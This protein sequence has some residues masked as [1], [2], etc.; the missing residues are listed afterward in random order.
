M[1]W[2]KTFLLSLLLS[3]TAI[4][5]G[6]FQSYHLPQIKSWLLLTIEKESRRQLPVQ[7]SSKSIDITLF[8]IG[9]RVYDVQVTPNKELQ[10]KIEPTRIK[11]ISIYLSISSLFKKQI[12]FKQ[13]KFVGGSLRYTHEKKHIPTSQKADNAKNLITSTV[14]DLLSIKSLQKLMV[15][16]LTLENIDIQVRD[17]ERNSTLTIQSL[18]LDLHV[19]SQGFLIIVNT[20]SLTLKEDSRSP[21][22]IDFFASLRVNENQIQVI[23]S[24]IKQGNGSLRTQGIIRG[25]FNQ[26]KYQSLDLAASGRL[27]LQESGQLAKSLFPTQQIPDLTGDAI[28]NIQAKHKYLH[29]P[30]LQIKLISEQTSI[31]KLQLG[32]LEIKGK[33]DTNGFQTSSFQIKN[34]GANV[35]I[36][37]FQIKFKDKY[38]FEGDLRLSQLNL[39]QLLKSINGKTTP[40]ELDGSGQ[41]PCKGQLKP[42]FEIQC[43]QLK[44]S[45][46]RF[47]I[48]GKKQ[49]GKKPNT[50]LD[51]KKI[52]VTEGDLQITKEQFT[53]KSN[54]GF[55]EANG[56]VNAVVNLQKNKDFHVK[57]NINIKD[58]LKIDDLVRL[59]L[60]GAA[61]VNGY[62]RGGKNSSTSITAN[63]RGNQ[64]SLQGWLLGSTNIPLQY[65]KGVIRATQI[66]GHINSSHY[67]GNLSIN[68]PK[69]KISLN[70]DFPSF[71]GKPLNKFLKSKFKLNT[72]FNGIGKL[73][74]NLQGDLSQPQYKIKSN[75]EGSLY[76]QSFDSLTFNISGKRSRINSDKILIQKG[77]G[78]LS[79]NGS[80]Y[81]SPDTKKVHANLQLKGQGIDIGK[82]DLLKNIDSNISGQL[83]FTSD[84]TGPTQNI[85]MDLK[86]KVS[87]F[88][89]DN[90]PL[91]NSDFQVQINKNQISGNIQLMGKTVESKFNLHTDHKGPFSLFLKTKK[92]NFM[93]LLSAFS[94]YAESEVLTSSITSQINLTSKNGNPW[95]SHGHGV[96]SQLEIQQDAKSMNTPQPIEFL[97][98]NGSMNTK[99]FK[100]VG[101]ESSLTLKSDHSTQDNLNIHLH[102]QIDLGFIKPF[103]PSLNTLK[104]QV[105]FD[106]L[107]FGPLNKMKAKGS[108]QIKRSTIEFKEF[109][110]PIEGL[111]TRISFNKHHISI[112]DLKA[113]VAGGELLS[114][115]TIHFKGKNHT[116]I[117]IKTYFNDVS[118]NMPKGIH[119]NGYGQ[120]ELTGKSPP[121]N[122]NGNYTIMGGNVSTH[123]D[124]LYPKKTKHI[125]IRSRLL[126]QA[127]KK[128]D[129]PSPLNLNFSFD[130]KNPLIVKTEFQ[131]SKIDARLNGN[132]KLLGPAN[133][134]LA[135]GNIGIEPGGTFQM[136]SHTFDI[137][138]AQFTYD[139]SPI[140]RPRLLVSSDTLIND[141]NVNLNIQ[142]NLPNP[143]LK[144]TSQ[145]PIPEAEISSLLAFGVNASTAD[146]QL[147]TYTAEDNLVTQS[148]LQA[149]STFINEKLGVSRRIRSDLGIQLDLLPTYDEETGEII[150]TI[151]A[152]QEWSPKL[153]TSLSRTLGSSGQTNRLKTEYRVNKRLLLIGSFERKEQKI[154]GTKVQE[155]EPDIFGIDLEYKLEFNLDDK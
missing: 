44:F 141:I 87:K 55:P 130:I 150:P 103:I 56:K 6:F 32:T 37:Q 145:P 106:S 31:N 100:L 135:Q 116:P 12:K 58:L 42:T 131:G 105:S 14:Q 91:E 65:R 99:N 124:F 8:P 84:F 59:K 153:K 71:Q 78:Y 110:H 144:L 94:K 2:K 45:S 16:R 111:S 41:F 107:I 4:L 11:H 22:E 64:F 18:N 72:M 40:L 101:T 83:D 75:F 129:T 90:T 147:E 104:G 61:K 39:Q 10:R 136:N 82:L 108:A 125:Q 7:I 57:Y 133:K 120:F 50:I 28:I 76:R 137:K 143:T 27:N 73:N 134:I 118:L 35:K 89:M 85:N 77:S 38:K 139:N 96:I 138:A 112:N 122:L 5:I 21:L 149:A 15:H 102:G 19:I 109:P 29:E 155:Q 152:T 146:N 154:D 49:P 132:L 98:S 80:T 95:K 3:V 47:H 128:E 68:L 66:K 54:I 43:T 69:K 25:D 46:N 74:L 48:L 151:I 148:T 81:E 52:H 9:C 51:L 20:P 17:K 70:I 62:I 60:K 92:W 13:I 114:S 123:L 79:L 140:N 142:G 23:S 1:S 126:S 24:E 127:S 117:N 53:Y 93:R 88:S 63:I 26:F 97:F 30:Q 36:N 86:G 113:H 115:G 34:K 121:Y 119:T 33:T 67:S